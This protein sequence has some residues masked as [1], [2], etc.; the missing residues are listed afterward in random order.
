MENQFLSYRQSLTLKK[1]GFNEECFGFYVNNGFDRYVFTLE[2]PK[3]D[4]IKLPLFQQAFDFFRE[5]YNFPSYIYTANG[6]I[7][8]YGI[9]R[10][11]RYLINSDVLYVTYQ[12]ARQACIEK[13]IEITKIN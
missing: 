11:N 5:K 2:H 3:K 12:E 6:E 1:L 13:L 9:L 4:F 10:E 7:Y 8:H